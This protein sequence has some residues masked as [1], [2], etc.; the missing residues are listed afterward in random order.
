MIYGLA[1][2]LSGIQAGGRILNTGANNIANAQ[3]ESFKRTRALPL[4]T[5]TGGVTVTLEK[6]GRPGT[7][8]SFQEDPSILR[9]GSNVDLGEEFIA[10]FQALRLVEANIASFKI[11]NKVLGS[12]LDITE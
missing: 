6:D 10:N 1:S 11:Q 7:Y 2:A 4:E 9:E 5:S 8:F 12:L 3:T